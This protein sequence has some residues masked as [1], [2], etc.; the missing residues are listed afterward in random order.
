MAA[1]NFHGIC[2]VKP[3]KMTMD[4]WLEFDTHACPVY[5]L[6]SFWTSS[7]ADAIAVQL[8]RIPGGGNV[9][10]DT[11]LTLPWHTVQTLMCGLL[12]IPQ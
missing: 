5:R 4:C 11:P 3:G 7:L 2:P 9:D 12:G 10:S 6:A 8:F 1:G